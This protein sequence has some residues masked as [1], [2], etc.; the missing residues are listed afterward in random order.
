MIV[1]IDAAVQGTETLWISQ[2]VF[3]VYGYL[4][5]FVHRDAICWVGD[6]ARLQLRLG[7]GSN[8]RTIEVLIEELNINV[9]PPSRPSSS[10]GSPRGSSEGASFENWFQYLSRT[11]RMFMPPFTRLAKSSL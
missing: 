9:V 6:V 4:S 11:S 8:A 10:V 3:D 5:K 7:R 1:P 2:A